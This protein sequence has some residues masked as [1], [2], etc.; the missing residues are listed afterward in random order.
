MSDRFF[1]DRN[2]SSQIKN[3]IKLVGDEAHHFL[4][5]MRGKTGDSITLFDGSGITFLGRVIETQKDS[6]SI[7]IL[8]IVPDEIESPIRLTV[9][10]AL[11]KGDRQ[12]FLVE[13]LAE[14]GVHR[15]IPIRLDRSVAKADS[16]VI[17]R[18]KRTVIEAAK[19]CDRN[20][21]MEIMQEQSLR[22]LESLLASE[23][24]NENLGDR[25]VLH[26]ISLGNVG[27]VTPPDI[28][29]KLTKKVTVL[30]GPEGSFTDQ[31][32]TLAIQF[33][34]RPLEIGKRI[35]RTETAGIAAAA[36]FLTW[37]G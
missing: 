20:V 5:V 7:D 15:L 27:Q 23:E 4:R 24:S 3:C 31:E 28:L 32:V 35:L 9:A 19:Q 33:G 26:P 1:L 37:A 11:P 8:Q 13:K 21:L 16:G 36:I 29:G 17:T 6:I 12:K 34:F 10:T 2:I 18:L 22:E 14:L 30:V 25:F